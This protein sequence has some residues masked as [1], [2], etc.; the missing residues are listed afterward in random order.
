MFIHPQPVLGGL[1]DEG[2]EMV[3]DGLRHG[4]GV[5]VLGGF[6]DVR[7]EAIAAIGEW[8]GKAGANRKA[9]ALG[10]G[11]VQGGDAGFEA[12]AVN[13]GGGFVGLDVEVG[14]EGGVALALEFFDEAEHGALLGD[15][16]VAAVAA[17][18]AEDAGQRGILKVLGHDGEAEAAKA[19]NE[20]DEL[21]IAKMGGDPDGA[22][23]V[24]DFFSLQEAGIELEEMKLVILVVEAQGPKKVKKGQREGL[25]RGEGDAFDLIRRD[26]FGGKGGAEIL[27]G[28]GAAAVV[29]GV[30][31]GAKKAAEEEDRGTGEFW[32]QPGGKADEGGFEDGAKVLHVCGLVVTEMGLQCGM[33]DTL[34]PTLKK[35]LNQP[36]APFHEYHVREQ[37]EQLL[38][39]VPHVELSHDGFGNLLV[40][41]R[42]GKRRS[43]PV[44]VLGAHMDHPA[45]VKVPHKEDWEFLG[46]VPKHVL[47]TEEG[48]VSRK[49]LENMAPWDFDVTI[50]DGRVTAAACDDLVG[51]AVIVAVFRELARLG[52]DATV[53]AAFTRAEE[54]GF[55]GAWHLGKNWP[56]GRDT[57]FLSVETSRPVN[58][59]EMGEGPII[60]VGDRLSIF[61]HV[62]T[63]ALVT[64]AMEQGIRVQRCLLDAGACEASA[65]QAC[66][67]RS[68]G[69][70]VPL[71][72]YHNQDEDQ[73]LAPEFVLLDDVRSLVNLLVAL[74][75]TEHQGLGE[76]PLEERVKLRMAEYK[77]HLEAGNAKFEALLV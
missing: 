40:T 4:G 13:D 42:K 55:L 14:K 1:A 77:R 21:E 65:L 20:A 58:G 25:V 63:H 48:R 32:K 7:L 39:D 70:S 62:L 41:Y 5:R 44:W 56:F 36:T 8:N 43:T 10:E 57:A 49:E 75:G 53:H 9:E 27:V 33:S 52:L 35:L 23:G 17:Q 34:S 2:F 69:V 38:L 3:P 76:R 51:C 46:G 59:A 73:N 72:N 29:D 11:G 30:G 22:A 50:D 67:I 45:W 68:A 15:D 24:G 37:I 54:V 60:R 12:K 61:D 28:G 64:T 6:Q 19:E 26:V 16:V 31:D 71:G 74:V 18:V 47:E 66:G